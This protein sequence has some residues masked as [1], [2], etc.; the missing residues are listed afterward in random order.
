[1][2]RANNDMA[3]GRVIWWVGLLLILLLAAGLRFFRLDAQSFW[4]DEGNSARIA[5]RSVR[6]ILA[7]AAG[8][9]HPPL[10]YLALHYWR[11][12]AG[13]SEFALRALS[14]IGG[15]ALVALTAL[16]GTRFFAPPAGLAAAFLAAINPFQVYYSQEARSYIW[17][18]FLTAATVYAAWRLNAPRLVP[19]VTGAAEEPHVPSLVWAV[20]YVLLVAAGLYTHYLFFLVLVPINLVVVVGLVLARSFRWLAGWMGLHLL[21]GILYLPW[22][23]IA[24][25]QVLGWPTLGGD[26]AFGQGALETLRLLSL[27][28]TVETEAS[29]LALLGFGFL[30]L[31]GLIPRRS[32]SRNVALVLATLW[33]LL[34]VGAIFGFQLYREA[35]LK[36]MLIVSPAFCLLVGRGLARFWPP[37][38]GAG[39]TVFFP[40]ALSLGLILSFTYSSLH[41]LYF[42]PRYARADYRQMAQDIE[43]VARPGDAVIL[44]AANQWEVFTYYYPHV[45]RVYP[46]PRSRPV[47]EPAVIAELE[48]I[49]AH[50]DR[51]FAIFWA[52]AESDPQRVVERWLDAHAY[53]ATD[54]WWGGVRLVTYA[55]PA[56]PPVTF[57]V[58][59]AARF[60]NRIELRGYTLLSNRLAPADIVQVSLFWEALAPVPERYKVF[61]HLIGPDGRPVAQRDS[62]PG[63]GLAPTTTWEPAQVIADHYGVLI[64]PGTPPGEYTLAVGLYVLGDPANRLPITLDGQPAGDLLELEMIVLAS[65]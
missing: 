2:E 16:L 18:A 51:V 14:A 21:A 65:Q 3:R 36:F 24:L 46:L 37:G 11:A 15:V 56:A 27:G 58:P 53:K 63:G 9:I 8:D 13:Q 40:L 38:A 30:L 47:D 32:R 31:L 4:N 44:N 5:E 33:L 28:V 43:A 49:A 25:R 48:E 60:G 62:E 22:A 59:L 1:M 6:L 20:A 55:V 17:V 41:N 61:V 7:G 45:D 57:D 42:D 26:V 12:V 23:P 64:P 39:R 35:F 34:P 52:E 29:S 54:E 19:P 10:Y 50:H